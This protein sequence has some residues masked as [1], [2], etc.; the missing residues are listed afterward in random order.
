M[1]ISEIDKYKN[2]LILI[3]WISLR[4]IVLM[5]VRAVLAIL[6]LCLYFEYEILFFVLKLYK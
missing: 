5:P 4:G 1:A 3:L 6:F 2:N